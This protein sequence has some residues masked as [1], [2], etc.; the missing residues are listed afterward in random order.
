MALSFL[1]ASFEDIFIQCSKERFVRGSA[2][3]NRMA[4]W[5]DE[6]GL[7]WVE[8]FECGR[9]IIGQDREQVEEERSGVIGEEGQ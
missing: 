3:H 8:D 1:L 7:I 9:Q 6:T 2:V 4:G 5:I